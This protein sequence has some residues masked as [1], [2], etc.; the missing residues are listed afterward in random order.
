MNTEPSRSLSSSPVSGTGVRGHP[1]VTGVGWMAIIVG[2]ALVFWALL[3]V[4]GIWTPL[5]TLRSVLEAERAAGGLTAGLH[6]LFARDLWFAGALVPAALLM[7]SV[8]V[9]LLQR[10]RWARPVFVGLMV[11][12]F[13]GSLLAVALTPVVF[14]LLPEQGAEVVGDGGSASVLVV[15]LAGVIAVATALAAVFAWTGWKLTQPAVRADFERKPGSGANRADEAP[16]GF[17]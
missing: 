1:F 8:A 16:S 6:W 14:T 10:R 12:G 9:G 2:G 17:S 4:A 15:L 11:A 3:L 7:I 5:D 13:M